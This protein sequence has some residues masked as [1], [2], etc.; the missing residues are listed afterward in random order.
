MVLHGQ[1]NILFLLK[2][3]L[4]RCLKAGKVQS[5][6]LSVKMGWE[7]IEPDRSGMQLA[8]QLEIGR[9]IIALGFLHSQIMQERR[10]TKQA[11]CQ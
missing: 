2:I 10:A 3:V 7:T 5:K 6:L 4:N 11:S 9:V 1:L 8:T